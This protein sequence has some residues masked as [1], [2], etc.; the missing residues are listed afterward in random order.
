MRLK[1]GNIYEYKNG[2]SYALFEVMECN[3]GWYL[4]KYIIEPNF[5]IDF[6]DRID[7]NSWMDELSVL[8]KP[9]MLKQIL[10]EKTC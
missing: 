4:V 9:S 2:Y 3:I 10:M 6:S 7:T 5:P 1:V 8:H